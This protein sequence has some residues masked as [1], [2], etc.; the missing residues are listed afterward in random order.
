MRMTLPLPW[1]GLR[2]W[3]READWRDA[4]DFVGPKRRTSVWGWALLGVGLL[5]ALQTHDAADAI[6]QAQAAQ[7][8]E[9]TRLTHAWH[10]REVAQQA[11]GQGA[12]GGVPRHLD[13]AR[14]AGPSSGSGASAVPAELPVPPAPVPSRE[15]WRQVAMLAEGLGHDWL[16]TLDRVDAEATAA[17]VALLAL[18]LDLTGAQGGT[19][20]AEVRLQAAVPDDEVALRWVARLGERA[21]LRSRQ[22][23]SAPFDGPHGHY[24]WRVDAVWPEAG[25]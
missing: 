15:D 20:A 23:L 14:A 10:Q 18:S 13:A 16:A 2:A 4:I 5:M 3:R 11:A 8:V 7:E 22:A 17:H 1:S 24:A 25:P 12:G 9:H 21:Q 19:G 6:E